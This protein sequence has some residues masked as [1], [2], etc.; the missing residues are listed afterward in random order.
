MGVRIDPTLVRAVLQN[1]VLAVVPAQA[2]L[3]EHLTAVQQLAIPDSGSHAGQSETSGGSS[4]SG[5]TDSS[6]T[7]KTDLSGAKD[8][9][10]DDQ[11]GSES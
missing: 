9:T 8:K 10:T 4:S 7:D 6:S 2:V 3:R 11:K 1:Q 5:K